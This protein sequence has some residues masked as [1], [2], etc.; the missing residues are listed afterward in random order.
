MNVA[1]KSCSEVENTRRIKG[2]GWTALDLHQRAS[3]SSLY[4]GMR[5]TISDLENIWFWRWGIGFEYAFKYLQPGVHLRISVNVH[6]KV[7]PSRQLDIL[8]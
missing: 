2:L 5:G 8:T 6:N 3:I 7:C 4:H 1:G